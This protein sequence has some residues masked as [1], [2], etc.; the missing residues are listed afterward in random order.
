[1]DDTGWKYLSWTIILGLVVFVFAINGGGESGLYLL[2]AILF[3]PLVSLILYFILKS[4][5]K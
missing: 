2:L 4:R 5:K 1:M 3:I